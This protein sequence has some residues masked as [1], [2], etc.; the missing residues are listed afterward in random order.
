MSA[1]AI[2]PLKDLVAAKSRLSGLLSPSERRGLAQAMAEDVIACLSA[3]PQ[4]ER[5]VLVSDDPGAHLLAES[6]GVQLLREQTLACTGLNAVLS[7][8]CA[9]LATSE[10][11]QRL[12]LHADLPLLSPADISVVLDAQRDA[13]NWVV[14]TDRHGRGTNML[15][16]SAG[17]TPAFAF[18]VD[19]CAKHRA[20][21]HDAGIAV[22][23]LQRSAIALDVD[24]PADL[25]LL[26]SQLHADSHTGRWLA[27][28][29]RSARI[30]LALQAMGLNAAAE[31][32]KIDA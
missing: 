32:R 4:V 27:E 16:F 11:P 18:G 17:H 19:S 28:Q 29:H 22:Q 24:E 9:Q 10:Q 15:A 31:E 26:L 14:G 20:R 12:V 21:G 8:A 5:V 13:G 30:A 25:A 23:I 7:A 3:S 2:V 6:Y 1:L